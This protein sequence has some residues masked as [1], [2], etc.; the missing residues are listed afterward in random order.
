MV[1][2]RLLRKEDLAVIESQSLSLFSSSTFI[3]FESLK[4]E[5]LSD[6]YLS[7]AAVNNDEPTT[8]TSQ[9]KGFVISCIGRLQEYGIVSSSS[10]SQGTT[11]QQSWQQAMQSCLPALTSIGYSPED[12]ASYICLVGV[13]EGSRR[14]GIATQLLSQVTSSAKAARAKLL[15]LHVSIDNSSARYLYNKLG[16]KALAYVPKFYS[17][18]LASPH[19]NGVGIAKEE[20]GEGRGGAVGGALLMFLPLDSDLWEGP[21]ARIRRERLRKSQFEAASEAAQDVASNRFT[22]QIRSESES[23][24]VNASSPMA[25]TPSLPPKIEILSSGMSQAKIQAKVISSAYQSPTTSSPPP[26]TFPRSLS[27]SAS[28]GSLVQSSWSSLV[29]RLTNNMQALNVPNKKE[30]ALAVDIGGEIKELVEDQNGEIGLI[31]CCLVNDSDHRDSEEDKEEVSYCVEEEEDKEEEKLT[32]DQREGLEREDDNRE[33][34]SSLSS[35]SSSSGPRLARLISCSCTP[36]RDQG[37]PLL[38]VP[39]PFSLSS[40]RP[41]SVH[42]HPPI[43]PHHPHRQLPLLTP[44][45]STVPRAMVTRGALTTS[46]RASRSASD[47]RRSSLGRF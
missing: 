37:R 28:F 16:F 32:S 35:S 22:N 41:L 42:T 31:D 8:S 39:S 4:E 12:R 13:T 45:H 5:S 36:S 24:E 27:S 18:Q 20:E 34:S 3:D 17:S 26:E 7:L 9:L 40:H 44:L 19:S 21:D 46:Y 23:S 2:L 30:L 10:S 15:F 14:K 6:R 38:T 25:P 29:G 33:L 11:T 43:S 1:Y 47:C